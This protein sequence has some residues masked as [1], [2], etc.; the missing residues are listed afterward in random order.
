MILS[1]D[2]QLSPLQIPKLS[3]TDS[4]AA[5]AAQKGTAAA[6]MGQFPPLGL[7]EKRGSMLLIAGA[8]KNV[9]K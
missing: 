1:A 6:I 8:L 9:A 2:G 3:R 5:Q 4:K 7:L